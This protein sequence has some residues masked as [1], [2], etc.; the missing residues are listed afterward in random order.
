MSPVDVSPVSP[1]PSMPG[2]VIRAFPVEEPL[3]EIRLNTPGGSSASAMHFVKR[4][5]DNGVVLAGLNTIVF[6]AAIPGPKYSDGMTVGKFHGVIMPQVPMATLKVKKRLLGSRAGIIG[7]SRRFTSSAAMRKF[8]AVS[9][10]SGRASDKYG[11]PCS[12]EMRA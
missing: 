11:F 7:D 4:N 6:P 2:W 12:A 8:S 1:I 10:T 5:V 9:S 3:P